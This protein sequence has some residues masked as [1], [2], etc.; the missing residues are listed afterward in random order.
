MTKL[1]SSLA[2][3]YLVLGSAPA[4][5]KPLVALQPGER[6]EG[7]DAYYQCGGGRGDEGDRLRKFYQCSLSYCITFMGYGK[8]PYYCEMYKNEWRGPV[9][10]ERTKSFARAKES[11]MAPTEGRVI[12]DMKCELISIN[13]VGQ[14]VK[15]QPI[16]DLNVTLPDLR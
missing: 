1:F 2:A 11:A 9:S 12:R 14:V 13:E 7:Q 4:L 15:S 8:D 6:Y 10:G 16:P 3:F 5:A